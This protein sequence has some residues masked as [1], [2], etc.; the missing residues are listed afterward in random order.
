MQNNYLDDDIEYIME[1]FSVTINYR[2]FS[3]ALLEQTKALIKTY[4][5]ALDAIVQYLIDEGSL[6]ACFGE[7]SKED[8]TKKLC[9][10]SFRILGEG[11]GVISYLNHTFDDVHIID[12][13]F[14]TQLDQIQLVSIDG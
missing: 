1:T 10:P 5:T 4:P 7:H 2:I 9:E 13:E 3:E 14:G 8:V 6:F 11:W 12:V